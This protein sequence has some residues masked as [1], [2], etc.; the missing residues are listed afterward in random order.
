MIVISFFFSSRRRHTSCA[1]VT[2]VQTCALPI[3][4][5]ALAVVW[6][7][8]TMTRLV[9]SS[10]AGFVG[11]T[12]GN[13]GGGRM[14]SCNRA[15]SKYRAFFA[16]IGGVPATMPISSAGGKLGRE[17]GRERV[18]QYGVILGVPVVLKKKKNI[19]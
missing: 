8:A 13:S 3:S 19:L 18:C 14:R 10:V 16:R 7:A 2:G 1:L 5:A 4:L 12:D 17:S 6:S 9:Q 11:R 15:S